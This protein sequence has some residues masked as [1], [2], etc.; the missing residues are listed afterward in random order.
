MFTFSSTIFQLLFIKGKSACVVVPF[1]YL[2]D[3]TLYWA[4][5]ESRDAISVFGG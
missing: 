5:G 4:D 3:D 2:E 1:R